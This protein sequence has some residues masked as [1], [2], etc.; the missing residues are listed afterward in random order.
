MDQPQSRV[1]SNAGDIEMPLSEIA[2]VAPD[3]QLSAT[4]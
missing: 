2:I 3:R 4:P 1:S